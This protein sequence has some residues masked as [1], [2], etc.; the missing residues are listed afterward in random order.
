[1]ELRSNFV[2]GIMKSP[3][4]QRILRIVIGLL[5]VYVG[6]A[7]ILHADKVAGNLLLLDIFPWCIINIFAMWLVCFEVFIGVLVISGIWLRASSLLLICFCV[8]CLGLISYAI[9]GDLNI[10]CGCFVTAPTGP[11]RSWSSLWQEI[12]MLIGCI[13]LWAT[14]KNV[15]A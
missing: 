11:A 7:K 2:Q 3:W 1:M 14:T 15:K 13:W 10:H 4:L 8:I 12:L 9:A 6:Y 5:F